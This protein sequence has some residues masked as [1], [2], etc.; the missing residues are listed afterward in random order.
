MSRSSSHARSSYTWPR[1]WFM[2][3]SGFDFVYSSN[4][5]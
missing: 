1:D 5:Q 4:I 2:E 3:A